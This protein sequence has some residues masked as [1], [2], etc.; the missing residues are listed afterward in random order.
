MVQGAGKMSNAG[1]F[2][3][4]F[5]GQGRIAITCKGTP[6]VSVDQPTFADPQAAVCWSTSLQTGYQRAHTLGGLLGGR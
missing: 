4:N 3:C 2:N 1:L 6:V 5:S